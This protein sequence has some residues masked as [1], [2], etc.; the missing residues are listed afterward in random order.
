MKTDEKRD[1]G[2]WVLSARIA[3][4][5][6]R[7]EEG[8]I[9][10]HQL[11]DELEL[12]I[13]GLR[14]EEIYVISHRDDTGIQWVWCGMYFGWSTNLDDAVKYAPTCF[15]LLIQSI[16]RDYKLGAGSQQ[17]NGVPET[18]EPFEDCGGDSVYSVIPLDK[19]QSN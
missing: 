12:I 6:E 3:Q 15:P 13:K 18:Y 5:A 10:S 11:A 4:L 9:S 14:R 19:F 2:S 1:C 17:Y 8:S 7:A 16:G